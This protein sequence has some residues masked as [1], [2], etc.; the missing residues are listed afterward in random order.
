[1]NLKH[2]HEWSADPYLVP[3][4]GLMFKV[5]GLEKLQQELKEAQDAFKELDGDLGTVSFDANDPASIE[6]AILS[7]DQMIDDRVGQYASNPVVN[8]VIEQLKESY[9]ESILEKA[10]EARLKADEPDN[11]DGEE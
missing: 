3:E 7:A 2:S 5:T 1:M 9:R 4:R 11:D 10:A 6:A 8:P